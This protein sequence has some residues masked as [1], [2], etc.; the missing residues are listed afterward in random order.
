LG[1]TKPVKTKKQNWRV[2]HNIHAPEV[3]VIDDK[4]GQVGIM[5]ISDA[6]KRASE[7]NLDLVEI[8]PLAKPPVTKIVDFGKFR[9]QQEKKERKQ[10]KGVKKTDIKEIRLSPF[11]GEADYNTRLERI[12]EFLS[13]GHKIRAVVKFKGRQMDSKNFGYKVLNRILE[14]VGENINL[15][16]EPKFIGRHLSMVISPMSKAKAE[17]KEEIIKKEVKENAE[18]EN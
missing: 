11:I 4:E 1:R 12:K 10:A 14:N 2:N 15:D 5:S 6:L 17:K 8:A 3:R 16:M 9:Y 7:A 18:T 13:D